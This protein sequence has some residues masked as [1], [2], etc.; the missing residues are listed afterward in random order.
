VVTV[1]WKSAGGVPV[2]SELRVKVSD[3]VKIEH[4]CAIFD[5]SRQ[6]IARLKAGVCAELDFSIIY[7]SN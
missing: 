6:I 7:N 2:S 3:C 1:F 5:N 4:A